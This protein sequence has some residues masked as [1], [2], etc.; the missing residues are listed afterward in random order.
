MIAF[1]S[2]PLQSHI[3]ST[4][5]PGQLSIFLPS[6]S[7]PHHFHKPTWP[8]QHFSPFPFSPTSLPQ[9]HLASSAFFSL[10]LQSHITST[11][12][13]GQLSIFLP[14][15]SV[16]H[17]FHKPTWPAQHFSPFPFSPTSLPQTHLA[18]SAFFSL[19]LQSH[20]TST[21]PPGQLSIFL[22][23][24]SVPHHFHKPTWPAQHFSPCT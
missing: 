16:P 4:N 13:P 24:P 1:F 19:P 18:S 21:N 5:P 15:P 8:A 14:S 11:N 7:V 23:S 9:T 3:T 17:H 6:P 2:L 10:P 12:P 22:P 20:I